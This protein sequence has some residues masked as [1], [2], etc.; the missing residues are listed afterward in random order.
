[1]VS[2]DMPDKHPGHPLIPLILVQKL[3][4]IGSD[5]KVSERDYGT[6]DHNGSPK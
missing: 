2:G 3:Y 1:M 6:A 5:I 4:F